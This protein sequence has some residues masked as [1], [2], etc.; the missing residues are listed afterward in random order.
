MLEIYK[1]KFDKESNKC[2]ESKDPLV[3]EQRNCQPASQVF[4]FDMMHG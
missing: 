3:Q 4:H 1:N 2:N